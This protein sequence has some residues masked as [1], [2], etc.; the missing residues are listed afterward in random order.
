[1]GGRR[2]KILPQSRGLTSPATAIAKILKKTV[3]ALRWE[4]S[5]RVKNPREHYHNLRLFQLGLPLMFSNATS[6]EV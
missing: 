4:S 6:T 5:Q 3:P 2:N 1:M